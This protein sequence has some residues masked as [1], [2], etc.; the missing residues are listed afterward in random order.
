[1][2]GFAGQTHGDEIGARV[3]IVFPGLVDHSNKA[4]PFGPLV[5][6]D[7]VNFAQFQVIAVV[8]PDTQDISSW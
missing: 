5:G 6:K 8:V 7:P 3:K 2:A 4:F 1:L